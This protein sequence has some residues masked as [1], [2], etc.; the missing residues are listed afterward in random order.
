M[1][2]IR[3]ISWKN[4]EVENLSDSLSCKAI[5]EGTMAQ[6]SIKR[7]GGAPRH[8]HDSEEY[9]SVI[10]G[11]VKYVFDDREVVVNAGE[12]LVVPANVPHW[13]E[14]LEDSVAVL[15]FSGRR[16]PIPGEVRYLRRAAN[17]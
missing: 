1:S 14:A 9:S 7:G 15:F 11:V 12:V 17:C 10:S 16:D 6:L 8:S 3:K 2:E 5:F 4:T 13:V